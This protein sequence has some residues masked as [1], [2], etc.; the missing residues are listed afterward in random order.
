MRKVY[1][2]SALLLVVFV[3]ASGCVESPDVNVRVKKPSV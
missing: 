3:L 2:L 1:S